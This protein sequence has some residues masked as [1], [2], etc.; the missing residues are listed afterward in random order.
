MHC[1]ERHWRIG[2]SISI[3]AEYSTHACMPGTGEYACYVTGRSKDGGMS[4][5][6]KGCW[7]MISFTLSESFA[8]NST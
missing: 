7:D 1:A 6:G 2:A 8:R 5:A 3:R 4:V